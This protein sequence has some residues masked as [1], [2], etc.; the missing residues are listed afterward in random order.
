ME[1]YAGCPLC[2]HT[3]EFL[4]NCLLI[5]VGLQPAL[6]HATCLAPVATWLSAGDRGQR[7]PPLAG[8]GVLRALGTADHAQFHK[9]VASEHLSNGRELWG[10]A[11]GVLGQDGEGGGGSFGKAGG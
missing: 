9:E 11:P 10:P 6:V 4:C 5:K 7:W 2:R 3:G 1:V 8:R